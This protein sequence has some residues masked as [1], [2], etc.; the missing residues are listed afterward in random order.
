MIYC[1][2]ALFL[3]FFFNTMVAANT[4][5]RTSACQ[6]T[7]VIHHNCMFLITDVNTD[8]SLHILQYTGFFSDILSTGYLHHKH[9][10]IVF[11]YRKM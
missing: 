3:A 7:F 9:D 6:I 10:I 4:N 1:T 5:R 8:M 11:M 2:L